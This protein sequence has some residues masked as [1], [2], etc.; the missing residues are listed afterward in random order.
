MFEKKINRLKRKILYFDQAILDK[1]KKNLDYFK[2]THKTFYKVKKQAFLID[3]ELGKY[4]LDLESQKK[5]T[6]L[7]DKELLELKEIINMIGIIEKYSNH[8]LEENQSINVDI[9][10]LMNALYIPLALLFAYYGMNLEEME[11]VPIFSNLNLY[12][13]FLIFSVFILMII[14]LRNKRLHVWIRNF[15]STDPQ[16]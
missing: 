4:K 6:L 5:N 13:F 2:D 16:V 14:F 10:T 3:I 12:L 9:I 1:D 8:L 11:K 15:I 7:V